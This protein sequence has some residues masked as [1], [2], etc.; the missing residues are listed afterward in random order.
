MTEHK[1]NILLIHCDQLRFDGLSC[2]KSSYADTPNIDTLAQRGINYTR[3]ISCNTIC[4]PSRASLLTGFYPTSHG[5]WCNGPALQRNDHEPGPVEWI[6]E[7]EKAPHNPQPSTMGDIF[8]A[9]GYRTAAFGKVHLEP[10]L[11]DQRFGYKE[12]L[13]YWSTG[14]LDHWSGPYYGFEHVELCLGHN[15]T[16]NLRQG[17]YAQWVRERDPNLIEQILDNPPK[18]EHQLWKGPVPHA[19]HHTSW[20]AERVSSYIREQTKGKTPFCA[21]VGFPGPHHPFAPSA[22]ILPEFTNRNPGTPSD[23]KG[24]FLHESRGHEQFLRWPPAADLRN[25]PEFITTARRYTAAMIY[26]IDL[27]VGQILSALDEVGARDNTIIAFTSDHGDF[28]GDHG[29][30][31]KHELASHS[32]LHIPF[33]LSGPGIEQGK[34]DNDVMSNVDALPSL[35]S[36][37]GIPIPKGIQ[38]KDRTTQGSGKDHAALACCYSPILLYRDRRRDNLTLYKDTYRYTTY[39][40]ADLEELFD[41]D[42]DPAETKDLSTE[43]HLKDLVHQLRGELAEHHMRTC[44]PMGFRPSI[45]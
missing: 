15:E 23:F 34:Y 18:G 40:R 43:P 6:T 9:A 44:I 22:D 25:D 4:Q 41:H 17:H 33:L 14:E 30:L 5:L 12:S 26:Q 31:F 36:L 20:L 38:G 32:L 7:L 16:Q 21:F 45:F 1:P 35:A 19:L 13:Q 11:A 24:S 8:T 2:N 28:L 10:I 42:S 27:A 29:L 39:P 37:A 3:H